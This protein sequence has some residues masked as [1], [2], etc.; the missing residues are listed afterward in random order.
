MFILIIEIQARRGTGDGEVVDA[1]P[2]QD[3]GVGPGVIVS[4]VVQLFVEPGEEARGAGGKAVGQGEGSGGLEAV[5]RV[6]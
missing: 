6:P 1:D 5:E 4:P 3:L 2:G